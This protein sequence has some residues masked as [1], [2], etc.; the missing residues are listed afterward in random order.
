MWIW[1]LALIFNVLARVFGNDLEIGGTFRKNIR[2]KFTF[3]SVFTVKM[4]IWA[5]AL[6]FNILARF[7]KWSWNWWN[8][9]KNIRLKF[10]FPSVFTVKMWIW[11]LALIFNVLARAFGNDLE[12]GGTFRKPSDKNSHFHRYLR[13]KCEFGLWLSF[14]MFWLGFLEMILKL[15]DIQKNIRLKFTFPS[16]FTVKM[17][18]WA[19]ALIFNV[20]AR[21]FGNDLEIGGTFRKTSD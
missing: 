13:W 3:P 21:V 6:I 2:L 12:I 15:G 7:W 5:L 16:V 18:I 9:Q 4:W 17:W 1:A 19:L 10:T 11:A 14:S 20:L 8:I